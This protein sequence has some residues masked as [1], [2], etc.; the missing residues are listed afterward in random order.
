MESF[1][2]QL[3]DIDPRLWDPQRHGVWMGSGWEVVRD[4]GAC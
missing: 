4:A 2:R 1:R 3:V